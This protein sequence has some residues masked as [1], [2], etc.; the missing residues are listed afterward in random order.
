MTRLRQ[1]I[2]QMSRIPLWKVLGI[3]LAGSWFV[4]QAADTLASALSLPEWAPALA[5]FLLIIGLPIVIA[6]AVAQGGAPNAEGA[7]RAVPGAEHR[8]LTWRNVVSGGV[9]AG[10]VWAGVVLARMDR[11]SDARATVDTP[12]AGIAN[13]EEGVEARR[14]V[15]V[16]PLSHRREVEEDLFFVDGIH[17]DILTQLSKIAGLKVISRTSVMQYRETPKPIREIGKELNVAT[18]LEGSVQRAGDRV[19]VN[20]QLIDAR[21]DGHLW[22]ETYNEELTAANIFSI[23][24]DIARKIA[25][26]L[27][28][29]LAPAV[30]ERIEVRPTE[31]L[32]AYELYARGRYLWNAGSM[33]GGAQEPVDLFS[34]AIEADPAYAPAYVGLARTFWARWVIGVLSAEE[35][36]PQWRAAIEQALELDP[37]LAEAHAALGE[38]LT[39]ELRLE[40]AERAFLR[41]LELNPGSAEVRGGYSLL[42]L[43]LRRN[44]E[45]VSEARRAVEL[46]PLSIGTRIGLAIALLFVGDYEAALAEAT[47]VLELAPE[48]A[49]AHYF[50]G[51]A[52]AL[53]G[54]LEEG[55]ASLQRSN[56]LDPESP[57]R[58]TALAWAY[59]RDGQ[60]ERA[61]ELLADVPE[62]GFNLKEMALVYG[63]L[64]ETDRAFAFLDRAYADHPANLLNLSV[65]PAADSLRADPRFE[66]LMKKLGLDNV[67]QS[68]VP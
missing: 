31:S 6:T 59:A 51:A 47:R 16:L 54:Q 49:D 43:Y 61:L 57:G 25:E 65:D 66:Q 67:A 11:S 28:A 24:S 5:L 12:A 42:L 2:H 7:V 17:E 40:D 1:F 19:R 20:V 27:Q 58:R 63:E 60:R 64:G 52:L 36:M 44:S 53:D 10:L 33:F 45:S 22:A 26:A 30:E 48:H 55:I 50:L 38:V 4:L 39:N 56:D 15:A 8:L 41:A 68:E 14:S 9:I 34:R 46:D 35:A 21:T 62:M 13:V 29:T 23:Q 18:I 32:A 37:D 3:Y